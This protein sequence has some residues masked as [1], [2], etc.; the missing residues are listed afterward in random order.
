MQVMTP[1]RIELENYE[2]VYDYYE[3]QSPNQRNARFL[4][5]LFGNIYRPDAQFEE[6]AE[7]KINDHFTQGNNVIVAANHLSTSDPLVL[8]SIVHNEDALH[9]LN[10]SAY[11]LGKAPIFKVK[12]IRPFIDNFVAVPTFRGKDVAKLDMPEEE[13]KAWR[14]KA[15]R[16]MLDLCVAKGNEGYNVAIFPQ[17]TRGEEARAR[18]GIGH[19]AHGLDRPEDFLVLPIGIAYN[20]QKKL[21]LKPNVHIGMP[22]ELGSDP[23]QFT[24][25]VDA[26]LRACADAAS[27]AG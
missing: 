17:G 24:D 20:E 14:L 23:I 25:E 18:P 9:P 10:G 21:D 27:A 19:I 13:K 22:F 26:R 11:I 4:H 8:A 7:D 5:R 15:T 2:A 16:R 3:Q 6:G 1:P 12:P